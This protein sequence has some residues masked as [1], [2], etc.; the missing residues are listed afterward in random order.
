V[1]AD[2]LADLSALKT[3]ARRLADF[4]ALL[5]VTV[6][7]CASCSTVFGIVDRLSIV[8]MAVA[9]ISYPAQRLLEIRRA[10]RWFSRSAGTAAI[11][12][13]MPLML[14][15]VAYAAH[16]SSLFWQPVSAPDWTRYLGMALALGVV[17]SRPVQP[18]ERSDV[19][20][21]CCV[22]AIEWRSLLLVLSFLLLS[23]SPSA[24]ALSTYWFVASGLER[25]FSGRDAGATGV[26]R[27]R[28][29]SVISCLQTEH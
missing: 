1:R 29:V 13:I 5:L 26:I 27:S 24:A 19:G 15:P 3:S 22:P 12:P 21:Q 23:H 10:G 14:V 28:F 18:A 6:G 4:P 11:A 20:G 7:V 2:V 8:M 17:I 25:I 16:P 9:Y